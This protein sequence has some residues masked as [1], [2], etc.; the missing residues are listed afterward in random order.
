MFPDSDDKFF[1][2]IKRSV[3]EAALL[4]QSCGSESSLDNRSVD[5]S[6]HFFVPIS[7]TAFSRLGTHKKLGSAK[8]KL[9][10][11]SQDHFV[12][13]SNNHT[14]NKFKELPHE[15]ETFHDYEGGNILSPL[16]N[17]TATVLVQESRTMAWMM[18]K[19]KY[20]LLLC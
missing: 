20:S 8:N 15:M 6:E 19:N 12:R 4:M 14:L 5:S 7:T 11:T 1:Q 9:L 13:A 17:S 18:F 16:S 10:S 2:N 3:R